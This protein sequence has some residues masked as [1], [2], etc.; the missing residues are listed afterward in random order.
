[1]PAKEYW[2]ELRDVARQTD[3]E[4]ALAQH[5]AHERRRL[6]R[7]YPYGAAWRESQAYQDACDEFERHVLRAMEEGNG[8]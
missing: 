3:P 2:E 1:L 8:D 5:L 4:L 6:F 7:W